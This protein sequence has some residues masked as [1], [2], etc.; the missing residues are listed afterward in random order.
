VGGK[1][2]NPFMFRRTHEMILKG[3]KHMSYLEGIK[4]VLQTLKDS[5]G[6]IYYKPVKIVGDDLM[7]RDCFFF[8]EH[9]K[10]PLLKIEN[11]RIKGKQGKIRT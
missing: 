8:G 10:A 1:M 2:K 9:D 6:R 5:K 4:L 3:E 11:N 7:V